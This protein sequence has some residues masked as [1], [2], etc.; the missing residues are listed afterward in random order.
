MPRLHRKLRQLVGKCLGR[1][2]IL[3]YHRVTRLDPDPWGM[4]VSPA[5]FSEQMEVIS[6]YLAPTPTSMLAGHLR[7]RT[8]PR[9][10]VA[11][12]FD[13]GYADNLYNAMPVLERFEIPATLFITTGAI[14]HDSEF[15]WDELE[16][17][18]SSAVHPD[19]VG[20]NA[21]DSRWQSLVRMPP[22]LREATLDEMAG[23]AGTGRSARPSH[24]VL[25]A[26]ELV[27]LAGNDLIDIGAHSVTHTALSVL[28]AAA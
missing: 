8:L 13:D 16:R 5:N 4:A 21:L 25:S 12:T 2:I 10:S 17:I 26:E 19:P 22:D 23:A 11:V 15:W 14:D 1:G 28:D 24:R 20:T 9:T 7:T 18:M 27:T 3:V 6:R